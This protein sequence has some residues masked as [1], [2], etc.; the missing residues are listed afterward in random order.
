M[1]DKDR[2]EREADLTYLDDGM[3]TLGPEVRACGVE[4]D[5]VKNGDDNLGNSIAIEVLRTPVVASWI[6]VAY[7]DG[8]I[9]GSCRRY[10]SAGR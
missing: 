8:R 10:C 3:E 7:H 4:E 1:K 5:G 9:D 2:H 6:E